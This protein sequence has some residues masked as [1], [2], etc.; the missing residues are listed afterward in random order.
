MVSGGDGQMGKALREYLPDAVYLGRDELDVTDEGSVFAAHDKHLPSTVIHLAAITDHQCPD[1]P[2]LI[3]TNIVGTQFMAKYAEPF[4]VK[5]VYLSTHYVYPGERGSYKEGDPEKPVG[6][7]AWTKYAGEQATN[8][9]VDRLIIRG[10]W[11]TKAKLEFWKEQAL[12]DA[13]SNREPVEV[14]AKKVALL[15]KR[16]A[17]GIY[18]IGGERRTFFQISTDEGYEA[19]P[20]KR[21]ELNPYIT[22]RFPVDSSVDT[23]KYDAFVQA[24]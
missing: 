12:V 11:Y 20:I 4:K 6:S 21:C 10:S 1:I 2:K 15:V 3:Q 16:K 22:Y 5:F 24:A 8:R 7:Y 14:A 19:T 17:A 9:L 13:W 18:N 23:A